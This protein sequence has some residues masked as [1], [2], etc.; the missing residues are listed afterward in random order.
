[1]TEVLNAI[2]NSDLFNSIGI[3]AI[4]LSIFLSLFFPMWP[5]KPK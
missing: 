3:A 5:V 4:L 1:M 2:I